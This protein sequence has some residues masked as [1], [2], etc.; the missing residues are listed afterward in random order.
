MERKGW[1]MEKT[2]TNRNVIEITI[3]AEAEYIDIVRLTLYGLTTHM[4]FSYEEIEDMKVAVSEACNNAVIHGYKEN[5]GQIEIKFEMKSDRIC[6][7]IKD[8]GQSFDYQD[9]AN[10]AGPISSDQ[11][12]SD[13]TE[14][15]LGIYLMQ[16]LM[17]EVTFKGD[18]AMG[19]EVFLTK[20]LK[21]E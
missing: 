20:L 18:R 15:E 9:S 4:G 21:Q 14:G 7:M 5:T 2:K 3:P 8:K 17:D 16:S 1:N 6:I 19:T 13:V 12:I 11:V 10:K